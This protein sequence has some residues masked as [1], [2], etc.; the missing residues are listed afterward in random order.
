MSESPFRA[1]VEARDISLMAACLH[2][3]VVFR[4][5]AV[6]K[7]YAGRDTVMFILSA[8][9][10]VFEDFHYVAEIADG[11]DE[12]LRFNARVGE[13]AIDGVDIVRYDDSGLVTELSV[14]VRPLSALQTLASAMGERLAA[15]MAAAGVEPPSA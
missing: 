7:P 5:P 6:F 10:E 8:V 12:M 2:P 3:D 4:S 1:A 11:P 9:F 13:R 15:K 14:M